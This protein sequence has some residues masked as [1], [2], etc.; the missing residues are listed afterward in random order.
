[1]VVVL[2]ITNGKITRPSASN[3]AF[4]GMMVL[5]GQELCETWRGLQE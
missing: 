5:L 4:F 3:C 2:L 1:M